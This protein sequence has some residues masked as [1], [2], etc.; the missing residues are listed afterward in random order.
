[1]G[2]VPSWRLRGLLR[3]GTVPGRRRLTS[4]IAVL[5]AVAALLVATSGDSVVAAPRS[6]HFT[7]AGDY[8]TTANA[9]SVLS[10]IGASGAELNLALGDL[11]YGTTGQEQAFCDF[12][13]SRVGAGFPFELISGNHESN[14]QNGNINDFSACLPNQVPGA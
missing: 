6:V 9:A 5:G 4:M 13:A 8:S 11:S 12:V 7:T 10:G 3:G 1:M 14:G 2:C